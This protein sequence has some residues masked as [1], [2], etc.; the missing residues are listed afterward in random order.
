MGKYSSSPF[1]RAFGSW[2]NALIKA[3]LNKTRVYGVTNEE[4][5]INIKDIWIKLGRQPKYSEI[6]KPLSKFCAGAYERRFGT[7]R[8]S[9]EAFIKYINDEDAEKSTEVSKCKPNVNQFKTQ[10][11]IIKH[12]TTKNINDRLRFIVLK[13]DNFKCKKCGRSPATDPRII[14]H[15]DHIHAWSQGGETILDNLQALCSQC[16]IGKS[17]LE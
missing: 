14:L 15:V 13:R 11:N 5:F 4:Y 16:N 1:L 6:Q 17:N 12:K 10:N 3:E 8:K 2:F 7:W 9:L